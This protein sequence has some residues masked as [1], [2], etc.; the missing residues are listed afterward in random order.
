MVT[1]LPFAGEGYFN[2]GQFGTL[3]IY[4]RAII[5]F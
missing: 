5:K 3:E 2:M 4:L 1:A